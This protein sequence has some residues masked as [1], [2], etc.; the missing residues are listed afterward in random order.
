M[1]RTDSRQL[2]PVAG[3]SAEAEAIKVAARAQQTLI[4]ERTRQ[5][6]RLRHQLRDYFPAALEAFDD[7][8]APETLELLASA[9]D[10][11]SAARLTTGQITRARPGRPPWRHRQGRR[12][13]GGTAR[14]AYA[15]A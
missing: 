9:P 3:D 11:A 5:V 2:R 12:D 1:V 7:L 14:G 4:W 15:P 8:A 10:P 13:R 6:Q